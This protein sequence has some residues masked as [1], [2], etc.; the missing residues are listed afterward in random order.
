MLVG[1]PEQKSQVPIPIRDYWN[2][3]EE[4]SLHN[5][6]LF[7]R[8][9]IIISKTIRPEIIA[10]S[11]SSH[12]GIESR[13][14]K[15]RDSVFWPGMSS[16]IKEAISQCSV[17]AEFQTRN[18]KEPMQTSKVPDR[19]WSRVAV[20]MFT[21]QRKEYVVLVD[22]YS[23]FAEVQEV[24]DTTSPTIIQFLKEQFSRHG[25][26]DV[27]V[28]DNGPQLVSHEFNRFAAEWEFKH[29]TSSPH[30]H[31]ANGKAESAV[32]VTKNLFK[33][34]LRDSRDPWLT[35]LEYRNTPVETIGS[36]PAQRL[37]SRRTKTLMPTASTLLRP[38]VV[39]GV[40]KKIELKRQKAKSYYDRSAHPLP[41]LE[42]GQEV[43]VAPL[44][45]GQSWQPGTLVEQLSDRSYLVKTGS[46]NIRR[47]RHF[48]KPKE[49]SVSNS[50]KKKP[51]EVAQEQP[52]AAASDPKE[53]SANLPD[54]A[55]STFAAPESDIPPD[56]VTA[57][58]EKRTR[59]RV[60]KPP[61]RFNDFVS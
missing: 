9:R 32:K 19:P 13:L 3:R 57:T 14:R 25:I 7:K 54:P 50:T 24:A 23:D 45:K 22:Y 40:E 55:T 17:C 12:L 52:V 29:V 44:K 2:Y 48:L 18:P 6:I 39:E 35:L 43:R 31:K 5:G 41:Q 26:P 36:S 47:N 30:H 33:K 46:D 16:D 28:S 42:I 59:T 60:V 51:T 61:K 34:A 21:L 11:H 58:Q 56:P 1:W 38:Q 15:A 53:N 27:L 49:Q 20:D 10:R 4:I 37:M 8:R